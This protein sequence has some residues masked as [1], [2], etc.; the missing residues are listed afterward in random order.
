M[1]WQGSK[2]RDRPSRRLFLRGLGGACIAAPFLSSLANRSARGAV[3]VPRRLVF[4]F[5]HY[6]CLTTRFFPANAHGTLTAANLDATTLRHLGPYADKLLLPRGIRAMNEWTQDMT[7]GQ[8]GD[9]HV[10]VGSFFTCEPFLPNSD[11]P[12]GVVDVRFPQRPIGRSL[13]HVIAEQLSPE[14]IPLYVRVGNGS[15]SPQSSISFSAPEEEYPG[16]GSPVQVFS[17][18]TG[19]FGAT[20]ETSP[21]SYRAARGKSV[22]DMVRTDLE[23]LESHD[24]SLA[25]RQKLEAWK[26][27]LHTTGEEVVSQCS[28]EGAT[29]LDLSEETV[30]PQSGGF[31]QRLTTA[32]TDSLDLADLYSN[33]AVLAAVCNA[34]PVVILHYPANHTFT[35]L[36]ATIESHSLSH[37]LDNAAMTG[38]CVPGVLDTLHSIDDYYAQKFAHLVGLLDAIAEGD[39]T[40]L[41]QSA[42]V[43]FQ[44]CSDGA[45]HNL[46]NLPIVQ[47]GSA[48]GY[49]KTGMS[50]N[51]DDGDPNL[52]RGNSEV[53]CT[54]GGDFDVQGHTALSGT[55]A[56]FANAPINKYFCNLMNALGVK[57]GTDGFPLNGGSAEVTHFGRYDRT[58][59]F[60]GGD[61]NPP[62][63]HDPGEFTDLKS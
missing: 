33:L 31:N 53:W 24:L 62:G 19:L 37:R 45:A 20:A 12:F 15:T 16:L 60:V 4:M 6:G 36:G 32:V 63:I 50:I 48:G 8:G 57:A 58:E 2:T 52:T 11:D 28:N 43:W 38:T 54:E 3:A 25:D 13:D 21:D 5:T 34:N 61:V 23:R 26:E 42:A 22:V 10:R 41:D 47:A 55:P 14:G 49:F 35:D 46:N 18:L 29:A 9:P 30:S 27:L 1:A 39:G 40:L 44:E 7:R 51:V 59:D 56:Q 17:H